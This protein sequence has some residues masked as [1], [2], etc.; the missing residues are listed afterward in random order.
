MEGK[1]VRY[2]LHKTVCGSASCLRRERVAFD[3][4]LRAEL[5][6]QSVV[7]VYLVKSIPVGE[8][9]AGQVDRY[10]G[11]TVR[12]G[13]LVVRGKD[14]AVACVGDRSADLG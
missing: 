7:Y 10:L 6:V 13:R 14:H 9:T 11:R 8:W 4:V 3:A 12:R 5:I 2:E 1:R